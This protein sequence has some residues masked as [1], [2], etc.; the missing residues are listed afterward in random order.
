MK[1]YLSILIILFF[2]QKIISQCEFENKQLVIINEVG[3]FVTH[4]DTKH[5][6][7]AEYIELLVLGD[8]NRPYSPVNI[9]GIIIDDNNIPVAEIGSEPG[10]IQLSDEFPLVY[11]GTLILIY[12]PD[13]YI[14]DESK[15]GEPNGSGVYQIPFNSPLIKKI[16]DKYFFPYNNYGYEKDTGWDG[17][18][19]FRN[20]GDIAQIISSKG[21]LI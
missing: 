2:F 20:Y 18:I 16:E 10:Y 3:S 15:D 8:P 1:K 14:V 21:K 13:G 5:H 12:D 6:I 11:P 17:F 9:R 7:N 19:P 4:P